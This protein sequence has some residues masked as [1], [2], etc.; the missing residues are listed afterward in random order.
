VLVF[1]L[2]YHFKTRISVAEKKSESM[3]GLLTAVVKEI[4]ILRGMFG[5]GGSDSS[6]SPSTSAA[7]APSCNLEI[8]SKTTPEINVPV[9][10][11]NMHTDSPSVQPQPPIIPK[12]VINLDFAAADKIVVS[13]DGEEDDDES[14]ISEEDDSESE[15]GSESES[16]CESDSESVRETVPVQV[17]AKN[18][19]SESESVAVGVRGFTKR[20]GVET[21]YEFRR[22]NELDVPEHSPTNQTHTQ[23]KNEDIQIVEIEDFSELGEVAPSLETTP[24][25]TLTLEEFT[26]EIDAQNEE[27]AKNTLSESVEVQGQILSSD[28]E[29]TG[30]EFRRLNKDT[31]EIHNLVENI[32]SSVE[33][34]E[35]DL[36]AKNEIIAEP[37]PQVHSVEQLRKMNINQLKT[38]A[39]QLGITAD[40]SKLKKPELISLIRERENPNTN[41]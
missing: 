19:L 2:V 41:E 20:S 11:N 9:F 16:E 23:N 33:Q 40:I 22:L 10:P 18:T 27:T 14:T 21:K 13:D 12:E 17:F 39:L 1:L 28:G 25:E 26:T 4:K 15:S 24:V 34:S 7:A 3:Y 32:L 8:K 38:I 31:V 30:Y 5:L 35:V 6:L 37:A 29:V 36:N